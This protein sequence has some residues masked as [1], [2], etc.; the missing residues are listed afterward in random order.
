ML[1]WQTLRALPRTGAAAALAGPLLAALAFRFGGERAARGRLAVLGGMLF[2]AALRGAA[3]ARGSQ[4]LA[5]ELTLDD[6]A[7]VAV[8]GL[9]LAAAVVHTVGACARVRG[10]LEDA[11]LHLRPLLGG[12][13]LV[14]SWLGLAS[15]L[16][17]PAALATPPVRSVAAAV[18]QEGEWH[19][20]YEAATA[21]RPRLVLVRADPLDGEP[22]WGTPVDLLGPFE[23]EIE[24]LAVQLL[25]AGATTA[26][27]VARGERPPAG[28]EVA[29]SE[30]RA[31]ERWAS[32]HAG[33]WG[34]L[35]LD[36]RGTGADPRALRALVERAWAPRELESSTVWVALPDC[37]GGACTAWIEGPAGS[38]VADLPALQ[39]GA[40]RNALVARATGAA[41][42]PLAASEGKS[43]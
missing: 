43:P 25:A 4:P 16:A 32:V 15:A 8:L 14:T 9:A 28:F 27:L 37:A 11:P 17:L 39:P 29:W 1:A 12:G 34:V 42:E 30:V 41:R 33:L 2:L 19:L 35:Y 26:A 24:P 3:L 22:G 5:T 38:A 6:G 7:V 31:L 10:P 20:G 18:G 21:A 40:L 36:A 13:A 23:A